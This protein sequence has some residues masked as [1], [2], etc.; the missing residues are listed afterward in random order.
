MSRKNFTVATAEDGKTT[1]VKIEK[2][3]VPT[4]KVVT[5]EDKK[6]RREAREEAYRNFRIAALI[7]RA[8]RMKL[9]KEATDEAVE[10]LKKQLSEPNN[11]TILVLYNPK[12]D[13]FITEAL[14]N[15]KI[16]YLFKSNSHVYV[17][18]DA[19]ILATIREIM[20][21][22]A[23]IHPYVKK[24][25]PILEAE[26]PKPKIKK[27]K[28]RATIRAAA[29]A[30]KKA[31]KAAKK[32]VSKKEINERRVKAKRKIL[33][34][35]MLFKKRVQK[36]SKKGTLTVVHKATKKASNSLK[37]ASTNVKQAA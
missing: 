20:P 28:N 8:T 23:K 13:K 5:L 7:R 29:V 30:A 31:R 27:P 37:K 12:D 18:G 35:E 3:N 25:S 21:T 19:T 32:L 17:E 9:T 1:L 10:K 16:K 4:G 11:Y 24:K 15:N 22:S 33:K 26:K 6:K 14:E 2:N 36:A 34:K